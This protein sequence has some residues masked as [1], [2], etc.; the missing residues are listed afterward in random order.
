M[1]I[2]KNLQLFLTLTLA[3]ITC[4]S[5]FYTSE[6]LINHGKRNT[7]AVVDGAERDNKTT[8]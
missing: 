7:I 4:F 6:K 5:F 2:K 8:I 3:I 1:K